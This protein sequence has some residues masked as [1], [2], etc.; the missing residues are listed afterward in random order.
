L[1]VSG[2]QAA[3]DI[4]E[5]NLAANQKLPSHIDP[6]NVNMGIHCGTALVGMTRFKGS[7]DTRMTYT[8]SGNVTNLAARLAAAAR[9]GDIL[10]AEETRELIDGLWPV[11]D[12]GTT[13]FEG[14]RKA[15]A[16]LFPAEGCLDV[17]VPQTRK[18]VNRMTANQGEHSNDYQMPRCQGFHSG[19]RP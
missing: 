15:R 6:L 4:H 10:I 11:F 16:Y 14:D 1:P 9:E 7:I 2:G 12:R 3:F 17:D 18:P 13:V 5:Q 8:A 19:V